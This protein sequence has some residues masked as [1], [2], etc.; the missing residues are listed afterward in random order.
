TREETMNAELLLQEMHG[1]SV[2]IDEIHQVSN[3][4]SHIIGYGDKDLRYAL[5]MYEQDY[6]KFSEGADLVRNTIRAVI[7]D[8]G[9]ETDWRNV[10]TKLTEKR[11]NAE[12]KE[13]SYVDEKTKSLTDEGWD[14][15]QEK[16]RDEVKRT[17]EKG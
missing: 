11:I 12:G 10:F 16:I 3:A 4:P 14:L 15:I 5:S 13:W 6:G 17:T 7:S 2:I 1:R 8:F 9:K